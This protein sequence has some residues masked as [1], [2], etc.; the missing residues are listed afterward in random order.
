[1][2]VSDIDPQLVKKGILLAAK[3]LY[4]SDTLCHH[5]IKGQKWG[6]RRTP[7]Q[8]GHDK[9]SVT[10]TVNRYLRSAEIRTRDGVRVTGISI[11]AAEQAENRKVTKKDILDAVERS[12]YIGHVTIDPKGRQSKQYL[13]KDATVAINP[14]NGNIVSVWPTSTKRARRYMANMR[15]K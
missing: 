15:R 5:G 13:G 7:E 3:Y 12:L 4:L 14:N 10:S 11:H 1:M 9:G 2:Y 6:V 8:L